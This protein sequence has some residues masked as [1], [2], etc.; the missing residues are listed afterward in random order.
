VPDAVVRATHAEPVQRLAPLLATLLLAMGALALRGLARR[1]RVA[2]GLVSVVLG[3]LVLWSAQATTPIRNAAAAAARTPAETASAL[4]PRNVYLTWSSYGMFTHLPNS[5]THGRTSAPWEL[6]LLRDEGGTVIANNAAA[7]VAAAQERGELPPLQAVAP[8]AVIPTQPGLGYVLAFTFVQPAARGEIRVLSASLHRTYALPSS[9]GE[10]AFGSAP[11][12]SYLLGFGPDEHDGHA[13]QVQADIPGVSVRAYPFAAD[14]LPLLVESLQ[15]LRVR[16]DAAEPAWLETP[17][18]WIP[19]YRA[20]VD[21]AVV[22][23]ARSPEGF[24]ML[25]VPMGRHTAE[26][27]YVPSASLKAAYVCSLLA[28]VGWMGSF[29]VAL[30]PRGAR[31]GWPRPL[32]AV[33]LVLASVLVLAAAAAWLHR[34]SVTGQGYA[35]PSLSSEPAA[36]PAVAGRGAVRLDVVFPRQVA[37]TTEP[38]LLTGKTGAADMVYVR[39]LP[40][41]RLQIGFDHWSAG[42][43]FSAPID[44]TPDVREEVEVEHAALYDETAGS[45][46]PEFRDPAH[47]RVIVR[48]NGK[49]VLDFVAAVWPGP[50]TCRAGTNPIGAS[51]CASRFS[52]TV[53]GMHRLETE[54]TA[55]PANKPSLR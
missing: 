47:S 42:G 49:V 11:G 20:L 12:N 8:A 1:P 53:L 9:G 7:V 37:Q 52:G 46:P 18:S 48:W 41:H 35:T 45:P 38:L 51:S 39:Y 19:G 27:R 6:R 10:A 50:G 15:P 25:P 29:P 26:V 14:S 40:G 31:R 24:V 2:R 21:G 13:L 16:L 55:G 4:D 3:A 54:E 36:P 32:P 28:L 33:A 44:Y 23:V 43:P 34:G 30:R 22:R 17:R 5:F